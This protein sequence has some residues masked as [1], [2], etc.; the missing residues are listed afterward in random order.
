MYFDYNATSPVRPEVLSTA[1][2]FLGENF[3]NPSSF[4]AAGRK[5]K[6][7]LERVRDG[8]L[9]ALGDP[10]GEL[11]FTSGGTEADNLALRGVMTE[12]PDKRAHL[13]FSSVEHNA[14]L[15]T[16]QA[17]EVEGFRVTAVPVGG[18]G[19]LDPRALKEAITPDT[20]LISVMQANNEVGT[21]EPIEEIGRIARE[22]GI[23]FHVD[24]VQS[25][26]KLP[27][28]VLE[29]PADL[30]SISGHKLGG[31]KGAGALYFRRGVK[32]HPLL[33]GG[34][35]ERNLRA[36]THGTP[37]ILAMGI[38]AEA[39]LKER[40]NGELKRIRRLRDRLESGLKKRLSD[41]E[42]NGHPEKRLP[43]T[44]NLSFLDC[45]GETLMMALDLAGICASTGS[46]CSSGST[47]P[48]HVLLAMGLSPERIRGSIRFSLGWG[49]TEAEVD[50]ALEK[51]PPAVEQVRRAFLT[52]RSP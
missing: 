18:Q 7:A 33:F 40:G 48:S 31:L 1:Q 17:L 23:L 42:L 4:H 44:L 47:E 37:G 28:N 5:A 11:V 14:V 16:A 51:I 50:Q 36:G 35:H 32:L 13:I 25:F 3:G 10:E 27:L 22:R 26:G 30:V 2:A 39:A 29:C 34:P 20:R 46:A 12:S 15:N 19:L 41:V 9:K 6:A 38:A 43:G 49:T 45:D 8:L 21:V 52:H 24:A